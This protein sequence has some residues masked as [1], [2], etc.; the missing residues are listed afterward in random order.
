MTHLF[1]IQQCVYIDAHG[2]FDTWIPTIQSWASGLWILPGNKTPLRSQVTWRIIPSLMD[3]CRHCSLGH[4]GVWSQS[5]RACL[6]LETMFWI[7][8]FMFV[9]WGGRDLPPRVVVKSN[10]VSY[11]KYLMPERCY[12]N[13]GSCSRS[14][15]MNSCEHTGSKQAK[16]LLQESKELPGL[17]GGGEEP[18]SLLSYR[19]FYLLKVGGG[20]NVGSRKMWFSPLALSSYLHQSGPIGVLGVETSHKFYDFFV[21]LFLWTKSPFLP[22]L[23]CPLREF[24]FWLSG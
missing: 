2:Q 12:R 23:F 7:N 8:L 19:D 15:G 18:P 24:L 16:S 11:G 22:F 9:T 14:Q 13:L 3:A 6:Q 10:Q 1:C 20:T 21:L 17:L 5:S 4:H